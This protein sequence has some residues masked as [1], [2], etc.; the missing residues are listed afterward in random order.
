[1][2]IKRGTRAWRARRKCCP[3]AK[4]SHV[5]ASFQVLTLGKGSGK[6]ELKYPLN[7]GPKKRGKVGY[8]LVD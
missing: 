8:E 1:M 4:P 2:W 3:G 7:R 5:Y 6:A